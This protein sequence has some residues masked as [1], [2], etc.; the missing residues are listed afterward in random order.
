M[1][2]VI[3]A[4]YSLYMLY[5]QLNMAGLRFAANISCMYKEAERMEDRYELARQGGFSAVECT[6]P[7]DVPIQVQHTTLCNIQHHTTLY[8]ITS[9]NTIQHTTSYNITS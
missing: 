2:L 4:I 9:Y 7:Y 3:M 6:Y 8:N 1:A 5:L